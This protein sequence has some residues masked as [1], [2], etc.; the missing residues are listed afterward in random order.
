MTT[1]KVL[2][3]TLEV[4]VTTTPGAISSTSQDTWH[5]RWLLQMGLDAEENSSWSLGTWQGLGADGHSLTLSSRSSFPRN[6]LDA[7]MG[8]PGN[9]VLEVMVQ[10]LDSPPSHP[11]VVPM[12]LWLKHSMRSSGR[13]CAGGKRVVDCVLDL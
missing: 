3:R 9:T 13:P 2:S 4:P 7:K 1:G 6:P 12:G 8:I 10:Q 5:P 11:R